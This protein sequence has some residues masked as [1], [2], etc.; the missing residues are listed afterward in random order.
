MGKILADAVA[1]LE[2][3]FEWRRDH[4]GL[5]IVFE[6]AADAVHQVDGACENAL[7]LRKACRGIGGDRLEHRHQRTGKD[8]ANRRGGTEAR[9]LEGYVPD[10]LPGRARRS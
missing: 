10:A 7:S 2:H 9:G 5:R 6:I 8:V 1:L 4:G 3:F